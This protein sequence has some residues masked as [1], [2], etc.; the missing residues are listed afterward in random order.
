MKKIRLHNN[1]SP[2]TP[3][4]LC[5][6][7]LDFDLSQARLNYYQSQEEGSLI[8]ALSEYTGLDKEMI[9]VANGGDTLLS[10]IFNSLT[11]DNRKMLVSTP[12]FFLYLST[13]KKLRLNLIDIPLKEGFK[14][15]TSEII[16]RVNEEEIGLVVI[17]RPNNPTGNIFPK[18]DI[19]EIAEKTNANILVDE[20]YFEFAKETL[21]DELYN[22]KNIIILRTFS[23]AFAAAGLRLGYGLGSKE[24]VKK[25]RDYQTH[26]NVSNITQMIGTKLLSNKDLFLPY[27]EKII[28]L[29]ESFRD[30]LNEIEGV[31]VYPSNTNF[32]LVKTEKDP[33][34]LEEYFN[35][36][37]V[38]IRPVHKLSPL[39]KDTIRVSVADEQTNQKFVNLLADYIN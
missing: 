32:L 25:V 5:K 38:L 17:C 33:E 27:V 34:L 37:N 10:E 31:Y 30:K 11:G 36:K 21:T 28:E 19:L 24:I 13:A 7:L 16:K 29:R 22:Y 9:V 14:L 2:F 12:T 8:E 18:E 23:K 3:E 6:E 4:S 20:A 15:P 1:E 39:I 26:Y 35:D